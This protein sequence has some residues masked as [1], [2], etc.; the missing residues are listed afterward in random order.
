MYKVIAK[1]SP[2]NYKMKKK[3]TIKIKNLNLMIETNN[4]ICSMALW[5]TNETLKNLKRLKLSLSHALFNP[6]SIKNPNRLANQNIS[7]LPVKNPKYFLHLVMFKANAYL[8]TKHK[9]ISTLHVYLNNSKLSLY[10]NIPNT[11]LRDSTLNILKGWRS[12]DK[13]S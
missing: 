13:S 12:Q 4:S 2:K 7:F 6:K 5:P 10:L 1:S 8:S 11:H 9:S 3:L